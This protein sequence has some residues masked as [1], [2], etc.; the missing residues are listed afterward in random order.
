MGLHELMP[1]PRRG[2]NCEQQKQPGF[3]DRTLEGH[4]FFTYCQALEAFF[5]QYGIRRP[6]QLRHAFLL[7]PLQHY[8]T[9]VKKAK[10]GCASGRRCLN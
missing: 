4:S 9:P 1:G 3:V 7:V 10:A 5:A 2:G 6:H 8:F